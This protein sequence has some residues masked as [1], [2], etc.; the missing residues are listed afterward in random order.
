M[1]EPDGCL[2]VSELPRTPIGRNLLGTAFAGA[3]DV[4]FGA[5]TVEMGELRYCPHSQM[6]D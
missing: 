5:E 4:W 2:V 3:G 6:Q 1:I